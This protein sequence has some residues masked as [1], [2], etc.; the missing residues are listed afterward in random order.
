ML[1]SSLE[2]FARERDDKKLRIGVIGCGSVSNRYLPQLLSSQLLQ[3]VS[4]CDIKY[5]RAV[6]QNQKYNV[7]AETYPHIDRAD[8]KKRRQRQ[9]Q[10]RGGGVAGCL[11]V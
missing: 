9:V 1:L 4:L 5:D 10:Q 3:V 6:N 2:G 8:R 11:G 7:K